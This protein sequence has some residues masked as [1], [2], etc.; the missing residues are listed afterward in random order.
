MFVFILMYLPIA[1]NITRGYNSKPARTEKADR[2]ILHACIT[3]IEIIDIECVLLSFLSKK[4]VSTKWRIEKGILVGPRLLRQGISRGCRECELFFQMKSLQK[5]SINSMI[6]CRGS[7]GFLIKLMVKWRYCSH[8]HK[9]VVNRASSFLG[10]SEVGQVAN[11]NAQKPFFTPPKH[12]G[13]TS[14]NESLANQR[15]L[16]HPENKNLHLG[17][18]GICPLK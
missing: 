5:T 9:N 17:I 13:F 6:T 7:N 10:I 12:R 4:I 11:Q 15:A 8:T 1:Q 16:L 3:C 2:I 18:N 14:E